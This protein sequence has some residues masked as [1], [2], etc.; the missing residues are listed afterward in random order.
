MSK[1]KRNF[2]L[3]INKAPMLFQ[4]VADCWMQQFLYAQMLDSYG[5]QRIVFI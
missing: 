1:V 3:D 2:T 5:K 4:Q